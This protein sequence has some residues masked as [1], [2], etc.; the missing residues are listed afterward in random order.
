MTHI[1]ED[2]THK[3][4]GQPHKKEVSRI[5]G[6]VYYIYICFNCIYIYSFIFEACVC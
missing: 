3:M 4:E 2:L 5:L 1:S 6:I